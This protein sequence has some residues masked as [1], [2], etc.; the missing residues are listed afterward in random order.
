MNEKI[1]EKKNKRVP[2]N[3]WKIL[4]ILHIN[5]STLTQSWH[6]RVSVFVTLSHSYLY[7]T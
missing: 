5:P 7:C 3:F 1:K 6:L 4:V 2:Q